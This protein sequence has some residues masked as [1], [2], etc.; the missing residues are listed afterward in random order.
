MN[1]EA[2]ARKQAFRVIVSEAIM[3]ITVILMVIILAFIV[4]GYWFNSNFEVERQ[5]MLQIGSIPT[6]ANV[7][8]DGDSPWYQ[9][10][11][12]SK[13]LS[14]NEHSVT[15]TK[16]GYDSWSKTININ[17]GLLYRLSYPRLFLIER[18]KE[19]V[20]DIST[21]LFSTI[22]PNG[23]ILL[24]TNN[25]TSWSLLDLESDNIKST[26]LDISKIFSNVVL[27]DDTHPGLFVGTI[28]SANWDYDNEHILF[29]VSQDN[30]VEW[31]LLD[32][33]NPTR[34]VNITK[35]FA[36]NF[37]EVDIFNH[38]A[39]VLLAIQDGNLHRID[40][41]SHQISPTLASSVESYSYYDSDIIYISNNKVNLL[42]HSNDTPLVI[43]ESAT[44]TKAFFGKFYDH[45][46]VFVVSQNNLSIYT[47]DS[48]TP[49]F[50]ADISFV[51][52][53]VK[54]GPGGD[55]VLMNLENK[56]ASLDME[57]MK[58]NEWS[59]DS[60]NYNWLDSYMIYTVTNGELKVY[61]F[62]GL[63]P[64]I[65]AQNVSDHFPV[66]ITN[67]KWLYYS[68]DDSLIREWLITK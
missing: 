35:E 28:I 40:I 13:I 18:Q 49:M 46:Y 39:S 26:T 10:T 67:N 9:H 14:A 30:Q 41:N 16:D 42:K 2:Q 63:N 65:L 45:N 15:L 7:E 23:K 38:S 22:S 56:F 53:S 66:A 48:S 21:A 8:V 5:G 68:S 59:S 17:E 19:T 27:T 61:D 36:I 11:N 57:S 54:I 44:P 43:A 64:R 50:S 32:V 34:S 24:L 4:S 20:Y 3:V 47:K 37:S 58:I 51:P 6:G 25:T 1:P 31:V 55:Y 52:T 33:K 29:K 62:D 12:T 60:N